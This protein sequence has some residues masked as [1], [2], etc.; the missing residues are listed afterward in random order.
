MKSS[1]SSLQHRVSGGCLFS[2]IHAIPKNMRKRNERR[3]SPNSGGPSISSVRK[4][5]A[6][7][8]LR[9]S[10]SD[11]CD[12]GRRPGS[13]ENHAGFWFAIAAAIAGSRDG[14]KSVAHG[15]GDVS[16]ADEIVVHL[17]RLY[18]RRPVETL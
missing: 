15:V 9:S 6:G 8:A 18:Q 1:S 5:C 13:I 2:A 4:A 16:R 3:Q 14:G 10:S 12:R 11:Y 7:F 17:S